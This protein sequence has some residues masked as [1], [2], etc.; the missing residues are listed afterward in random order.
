MNVLDFVN[1]TDIKNHLKEIDYRCN[2]LEASW[3][4]Y[5]SSICTLEEKMSAWNWIIDNM[6]DCE[7]PERI[8]CSYRQSLHGTLKLYMDML[9]GKINRFYEEGTNVAYSYRYLLYGYPE[10]TEG[11]HLYS[12]PEIC[13]ECIEDDLDEDEI[14]NLTEVRI[15]RDVIDNAGASVTLVFSKRKKIMDVYFIPINDEEQDLSRYFFNGM[16][17]HFPVPFKKGD[18]LVRVDEDKYPGHR[19]AEGPFVLDD[20]TP[21]YIAGL[22]EE[23]SKSYEEGLYGDET[24]MNAWGYFQDEDGCIFREVMFNYM[25]LELYKGPFEGRQRLLIALSNFEKGN[26]G[27]DLLMTAYRK[28]IIDEFA[29]GIMLRNWYTDDGLILAGLID[30]NNKT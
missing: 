1:S 16:W 30:E 5:Q 4:I 6:D 21:L 24:D 2:Q 14:S 3:L 26:I 22:D 13:W 28:I 27:V 23:R 12:S 19:F 9:N 11:E 18:V 10:W 17:F 8:N 15:T 20:I 7:V 29:E 25:D